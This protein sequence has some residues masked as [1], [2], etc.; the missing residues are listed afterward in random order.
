M[1][2]IGTYGCDKGSLV[3]N[4]IC[5][6]NGI[7]DGDY[8]IFYEKDPTAI[9]SNFKKFDGVWVDLRDADLEIWELDCDKNSKKTI[10]TATS[11]NADALE[12]YR[13]NGDILLVKYF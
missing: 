4:G 13:Y 5:F 3:I 8:D 2:K 9:P 1:E 11:I 7:G 12:I 10:I 6:S